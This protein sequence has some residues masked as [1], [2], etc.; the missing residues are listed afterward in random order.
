MFPQQIHEYS[1]SYHPL[2]DHNNPV[3]GGELLTQQLRRNIEFAQYAG[4]SEPFFQLSRTLC[5]PM[6]GSLRIRE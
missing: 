1:S 5:I 2:K 6:R 4:S 3:L